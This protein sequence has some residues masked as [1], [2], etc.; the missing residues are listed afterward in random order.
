L[1]PIFREITNMLK[2]IPLF[3]LFLA[4]CSGNERAFG[5]TGQQ[6]LPYPGE[7]PPPAGESASISPYMWSPQNYS[8]MLGARLVRKP[9][10]TMVA[11]VI[12]GKERGGATVTLPMGV[13]PG[14]PVLTFSSTDSKAFLGQQIRASVEAEIVKEYGLTIRQ[15]SSDT[16]AAVELAIKTAVCAATGGLSC[17]AEG[18]GGALAP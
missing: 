5:P 1:Q 10:G 12:D 16:R 13:E 6:H 18:I 4:A 8:G 14:S 7:Q 11:E 9:D 2:L 17:V 3:F 15:L